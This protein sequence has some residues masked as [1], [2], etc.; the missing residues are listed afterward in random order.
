MSETIWW[1]KQ[2]EGNTPESSLR[3]LGPVCVGINLLISVFLKEE[4][5][6][7]FPPNATSTV[8]TFI[9]LPFS[10]TKGRVLLMSR[11]ALKIQPMCFIA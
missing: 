5:D 8:Q 3:S 1:S 6:L 2:I 11:P 4:D 7:L 9:I 10:Q